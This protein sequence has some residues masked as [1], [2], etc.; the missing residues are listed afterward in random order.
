MVS[1][2]YSGG[3]PSPCPALPCPALTLGVC[4]K[5][6]YSKNLPFVRCLILLL[7][8]PLHISLCTVFAISVLWCDRRHSWDSLHPRGVFGECHGQLCRIQY[9]GEIGSLKAMH[10]SND[11]Q[12]CKGSLPNISSQVSTTYKVRWL[13][14]ENGAIRKEITSVSSMNFVDFHMFVRYLSVGN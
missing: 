3:I 8:C 7:E 14:L 4:G 5:V 10:G 11:L 6:S 1:R 13:K 2:G 12:N 9:I